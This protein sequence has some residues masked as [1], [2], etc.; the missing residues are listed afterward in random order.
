MRILAPSPA[1]RRARRRRLRRRADGARRPAA[2]IPA[3]L[4]EADAH[5]GL[6][7]RLAAP[8]A[9]R[10]V[11]SR[12]AIDGRDGHASTASSGARSPRASCAAARAEARRHFGLPAG[13]AGRGRA[14]ARSPARARSTSWPSTAW[15][16]SG[17]GRPAHLAASATTPLFARAC[18][19]P[20]YVL[21]PSTDASEPPSPP[22][23]WPSRAPAARSGSSRPPALP[24]LL[25][26]YPH[27]TADHQTLNARYFE[28]RRRCGR[29]PRRRGSARV[30]ELV[31]EL[32][33]DRARLARDGRGDAAR[34]PGR[35]PPRDRRGA[36]RPCRALTLGGRAA[37]LRRASAAPGFPPTPTS[38]A[39]WGAE[40]ARLGRARDALPGDA[41]RDRAS[42]S[43]ASRR[44]PAGWEV[45]V[46][47]AH[48]P[49]RCR[50]AGARSFLAELVALAAGI[51]VGGAH[52]KTTT[53]AMIAFA[54]RRVRP[55]SGLDRRRRG[56]AARRQRR[57]AAAG[58]SS[59]RA[60]SPTAR[61]FAL[62][63]EIAVVTNVELDHHATYAS[64]AELAR[65]LRQLARGGAARRA[66]RGSSIRST[67][68]S[69]CP[70]STTGGT[71]PP[72]SR[73]SSSRACRGRR[74]EQALARFTG[75]GRRFELI[76]E[77]GGVAVYDDY[78][79]QPDRA[80]GHAARRR[81]SATAGV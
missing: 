53:A 72:R 59:S 80:R 3:A 66:Q 62:R 16:D 12:I 25:V 1:G 31:A 52:G 22:P 60:T 18:P 50:V 71:P 46:S 23:I 32:L 43:A 35:T 29:R 47:T 10:V 34:W 81:A 65:L 54:L 20:D 44:R 48:A 70:A 58:G 67:S 61:S 26:P 79:A 76:G 8:F 41:R 55:R 49:R 19:R 51:V 15:A 7:N 64:A 37:L 14:S 74:A 45:I 17:P 56:P 2:G 42:I 6:A 57:R 68:S 40:V 38:L 33:A 24:A 78:G 13:R 21:L 73:R 5:L 63:P 69:R 27:A 4:T 75:V 9:D 11:S 30:P 28:R 36:D 77:R 39:A